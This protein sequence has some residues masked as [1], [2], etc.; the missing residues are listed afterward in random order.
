MQI[1]SAGSQATYAPSFE[2]FNGDHTPHA[3]VSSRVDRIE[4]ALRKTKHTSVGITTAAT[5]DELASVHDPAYIEYLSLMCS[6]LDA[7]DYRYPSVFPHGIARHGASDVA[8]IGRYAFDTFSPLIAETFHA[9]SLSASVA[10]AAAHD[11]HD[12]GNPA[13][14]LCRPPGHHAESARFGGYCYFNNSALAAAYLSG[15]GRV[16]I[17]DVDFH[18]GNGTQQI[19]WE[20][21][22]VFTVSLHADP[23]WKFPYFT[24]FADEIGHG[25]GE[26]YN[27]NIPLPKNTGNDSYHQ[28][29]EIACERIASFH[30]AAIVVAYGADT[31]R[32]DPIGG[33]TLTTDY[34]AKMARTI[35]SLRIPTMIVQEGGY[36]TSLLGDNA[37][38]FLSGF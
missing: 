17:L 14:A 29:L 8:K 22:D 27:L 19:F 2:V 36:N 1:F 7:S 23:D 21:S 30:P 12:T 6:R 20:R 33:F 13:Y 38:S 34:Y 9:A 37:V 15:F 3:E 18:H 16:A 32:D 5:S 25:A 11:L 24:G 4:E 26:G 10:L 31:H 35:A 28:A